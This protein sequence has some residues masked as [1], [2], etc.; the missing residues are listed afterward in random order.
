MPQQA[1]E[2]YTCH[3][4]QQQAAEVYTCHSKMSQHAT[5]AKCPSMPQQQNVPE[6]C[7]SMQLEHATAV[8]ILHYTS[9]VLAVY[10]NMQMEVY[11][12]A[13]MI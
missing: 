3:N 10:L 4:K 8:N 1:A 12:Q 13:S 6:K 5:T 11:T 7:P 2:V 9:F